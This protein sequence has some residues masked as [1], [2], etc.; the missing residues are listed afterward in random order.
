MTGVCF[1]PSVPNRVRRQCSSAFLRHGLVSGG[2]LL[3]V[4]YT[5]ETDYPQS[6]DAAAA[7]LAGALADRV[8]VLRKERHDSYRLDLW[9]VR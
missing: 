5:G 3:L 4:H 1:D 9:R 6:G 8:D 7:S 2:D